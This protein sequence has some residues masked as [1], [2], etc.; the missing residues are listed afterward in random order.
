MMFLNGATD[1]AQKEMHIMGMVGMTASDELMHG[2]VGKEVD[3]LFWRTF[4]Y[5]AQPVRPEETACRPT[6]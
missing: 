5:A 1:G 6:S 3:D 2:M 4:D